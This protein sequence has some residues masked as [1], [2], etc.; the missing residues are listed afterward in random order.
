MYHV[1]FARVKDLDE[2]KTIDMRKDEQKA[3]SDE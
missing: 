1:H 3:G 2:P